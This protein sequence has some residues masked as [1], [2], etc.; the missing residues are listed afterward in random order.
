MRR[1]LTEAVASGARRLDPMLADQTIHRNARGENGRLRILRQQQ[2]LLGPLETHRAQGLAQ[3][4]VGLAKGVAADREGIG[5]VLAHA[6]LLG[7]LPGEDTRDHLFWRHQGKSQSGACADSSRA[8]LS[9]SRSLTP[10][11]A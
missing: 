5:Q 6:D 2:P 4:L 3:S 8:R 10:R 1:V 9:S 11:A 7:T